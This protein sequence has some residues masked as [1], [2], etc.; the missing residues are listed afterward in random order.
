M[1]QLMERAGEAVYHAIRESISAD[2]RVGFLCG[3]GNNGGDG[4]VAARLCHQAGIRV[5]CFCASSPEELMPESK[6]QMLLAKEAGVPTYFADDPRYR[7]R[8]EC[9][10]SRD[11][12][13]D[14]LLGTGVKGEPY[15]HILEAIRAINRSG[16]PVLAVDI[17]SG[18]QCDS[19]EEL[20]ESVWAARTLTLGLPKPFLFQGTGLEHSG[21]WCVADIG[22]PEALI[23][24]PT[25]TFLVD[26]E[27]A[28]GLIPERMR[29]SHK[30][31][32][33]HVLI[34]AGSESMP[35]A[36]VMAAKSAIRSG[37][38]LVTVAAIRYV[39]QTVANHVPE[40]TFHI[41]PDQGGQI[42]SKAAHEVA[43]M[44]GRCDAAVF[45]PGMGQGE[46]V[47]EFLAKCWETWTKPCLI[48]ADALNAVA[49]GVPLP[50]CECVL[51]P[52]PGEMGRLLE[53]SVA[54][55]QSD[56]FQTVREAIG[57]YRRCILLKGPYSIV[58]EDDMPLCV[59]STGNPGL[60][61]G[62]MGDVLSGVIASLMGQSV[63]AY[64][65]ATV[66]MYWHG[67]AADICATEIGA[68]GYSAIDVANALP[69]ARAKIV[70]SCD[71]ESCSCL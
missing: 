17:P 45:G 32:N 10:G 2:A 7:R 6:A 49:A 25:D 14:A 15:G 3:K 56:R 52:H 51:T 65:A 39:C 43:Q 36:V 48:D 35:G 61:S 23:S 27:M 58:G 40:C 44:S 21:Q 13:V 69:K 8:I 19:G 71:Y 22:F 63:P 55:V 66:G 68:V 28:A 12:L 24:E 11:L 53:A 57:R 42:A 1:R 5:D 46:E 60:A 70:A 4:F 20:G 62:G 54:E 64:Y 59:N 37:A 30:G 34:V 29:S 9:L 16:V 31:D 47:R 38:G 18:I 50:E 41:L 67:L 26:C 33:G